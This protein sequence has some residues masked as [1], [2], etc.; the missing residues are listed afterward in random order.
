MFPVLS[1][2]ITFVPLYANV[3]FVPAAV[4]VQL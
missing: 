2:R 1:T 3:K 4:T